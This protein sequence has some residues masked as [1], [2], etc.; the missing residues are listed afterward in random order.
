M[1]DSILT[2]QGVNDKFN[3]SSYTNH[4]L[5][6]DWVEVF[7]YLFRSVA[8]RQQENLAF[9]VLLRVILYTEQNT[10]AL[11]PYDTHDPR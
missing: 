1:I 2:Y 3:L 7:E 9:F 4:N 5:K 8:I 10:P 11:H 6:L